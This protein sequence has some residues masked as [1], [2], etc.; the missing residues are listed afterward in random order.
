MRTFLIIGEKTA[1]ISEF[2]ACTK[3][4]EYY[5]RQTI[6]GDICLIDTPGLSE[7]SEDLDRKYLSMVKNILSDKIYAT[8][9]IT[10]LNET[11][12]RSSERQSLLFITEELGH[13]IWDNSWIIFTFAASVRHEKRQQ[14]LENRC[15]QI[16]S[17][18]REN[19]LVGSSFNGFEQVALVDNVVSDWDS[20]A[21]S[22]AKFLATN[23]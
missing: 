14:A 22:I 15:F 6:F 7:G 10:P 18:I 1:E 13:E 2:E 17:F 11:R 4:I 23:K 12:L 8:L 9:Y 16:L 3:L 19:T 20:E 5:P 21:I